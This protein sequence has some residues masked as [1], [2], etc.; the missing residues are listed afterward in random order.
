MEKF[1]KALTG[2]LLVAVAVLYYLFFSSGV[3][4]QQGASVK[5]GSNNIKSETAVR[6][7]YI[8]LDTIE[9][10]YLYFKQKNDELEKE[11]GGRC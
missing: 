2:I 1:Y 5:K 11:N 10:K 9:E 6:L 8:D 3:K 7:A 4:T